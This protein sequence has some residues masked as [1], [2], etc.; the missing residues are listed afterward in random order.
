M[1]A[2]TRPVLLYDHSC[3]FCVWSA[4]GVA[5]LDKRERLGLLEMLHPEAQVMLAELPLE[6]R[7]RTWHL[8]YPDGRIVSPPEGV[9]VLLDL[10]A[11]LAPVAWVVHRLRL[12]GLVMRVEKLVSAYRGELGKVV[13][14]KGP[15]R[16]F[17]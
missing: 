12:Q 10:L 16:R 9:I 8:V 15:I 2:L 14:R 13:P 3:P 17:P 11:P 5:K 6:R 1:T 4:R 7:Y